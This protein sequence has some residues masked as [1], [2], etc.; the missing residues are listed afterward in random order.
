MSLSDISSVLSIAEFSGRL[1][2]YLK[3]KK[4]KAKTVPRKRVRKQTKDEELII[5]L[6]INPEKAIKKIGAE[7]IVKNRK[8]I[9]KGIEKLWLMSYS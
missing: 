9:I 7:Y 8:R 5:D 2:S 6:L 1:I 4:K 3:N